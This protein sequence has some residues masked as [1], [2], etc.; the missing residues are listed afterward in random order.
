MRIDYRWSAGDAERI[1]KHAAELRAPAPDV[2]LAN[3]TSAVVLLQQATRNAPIVFVELTDRVGAGIV[4]SL[5]QPAGNA[6]GFTLF[7]PVHPQRRARVR[8]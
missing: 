4:E 3:G 5:A 1:R 2:V 6:T 7:E 8:G